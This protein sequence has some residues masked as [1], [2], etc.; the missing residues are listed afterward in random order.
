M[1]LLSFLTGNKKIDSSGLSG[2]SK[3][4]LLEACN[5][6]T[7]IFGN[8]NKLE[9]ELPRLVVVGSQSAGKSSVLNSILGFDLLSTGK[10]MVTRT[11]FD[12]RLIKSKLCKVEFGTYHN[13]I[14]TPANIYSITSPVPSREEMDIIRIEMQRQT[15]IIAGEG[16]G[17][18]A[19][20]IILKVYF[21]SVP[22]LS[23]VDLPGLTMV[24]CTDR[25]QPKDIKTQIR[26]LVSSYIKKENTLNLAIMP[27][28]T[29]L[30]T[31]M[32]LDLIKE[33][34]PD[35]QRTIGVL[36]KIDLMN[37]DSDISCYLNGNISKDLQLKYGYFAVKNRSGSET[38]T[39]TVQD[40][41]KAEAQYF[42]EHPVYGNMPSD[43]MGIE[44]LGNSLS[45][46]LIDRVMNL[47][48]DILKKII[49]KQEEINGVLETFGPPIPRDKEG[50]KS[51]IHTLIAKFCRE[52]VRSLEERGAP[53]NY[54]KKIKEIF[55]K[56]RENVNSIKPF[57]TQGCSDKY[58]KDAIDNCE[59]NHMSFPTPPI[60]VLEHCMTDPV[61]AP[62]GKLKDPTFDCLAQ[63][64]SLL[65][66]LT[67]KILVH[68]HINK[69][70]TLTKKIKEIINTN[71]L[72]V[73]KQNTQAQLSNIVDIESSYIWTDDQHFMQSLGK[74]YEKTDSCNNNLSIVR[75]ILSEYYKTVKFNVKNSVP[76]IIMH[77]LVKNVQKQTSSILFNE[78]S[79]FGKLEEESE[80]SKKRDMYIA[81]KEKID[82][83]RN[84]LES[85]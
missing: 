84:I 34:D 25:G 2:L 21:P 59:G 68:K 37:K 81:Q 1:E 3:H 82:T 9:I 78:L 6:L 47:L 71:I 63:I 69:F 29:D 77:F 67:D 56:Y 70:P 43:K 80:T 74:L 61:L 12:I 60:E 35:G 13:N 8:D 42:A 40:A 17:I 15:T 32:A 66:E 73:Q 31:D 52:F 44:K 4:K 58:I 83:A 11:P 48:P 64:C 14:W 18:S 46:I 57:S 16:M 75:G 5:D 7:G 53:L 26:K 41:V 54:G 10:N 33:F 50:Q 28:R 79:N 76:K 27:A 30:E 85:I 51:L 45:D 22:N 39:M 24:A 20:P 55:I 38:K 36:T 62:I 19:T 23:L 49:D 72:T 65:K